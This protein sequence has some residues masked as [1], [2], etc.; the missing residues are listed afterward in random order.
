MDDDASG[1]QLGSRKRRSLLRVFA[2]EET[3]SVD[4]PVQKVRKSRAFSLFQG[5]PQN[6]T[7]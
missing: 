3:E 5:K 6:N 2:E 1:G 4:D 7:E